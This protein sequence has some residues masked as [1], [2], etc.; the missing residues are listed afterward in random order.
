[1]SLH[2]YH[3]M[4][5]T[6]DGNSIGH[7]CIGIVEDTGADVTSVAKGDLV[8]APV[9]EDSPLIPSLLTLSDVY[10]TGAT[11]VVAERASSTARSPSARPRRDTGTWTR[12]APSRS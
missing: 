8:V 10:G 1:V 5:V 7:E 12:A 6:P 9:E 3:F 11:E 4:P 2:P